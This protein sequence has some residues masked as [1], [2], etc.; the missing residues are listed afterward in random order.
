VSV[1]EKKSA[2]VSNG[3]SRARREH[4]LISG[5]RD[6]QSILEARENWQDD[7]SLRNLPEGS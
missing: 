4:T 3:W 1:C 6:T 5:W 7:R 2:R